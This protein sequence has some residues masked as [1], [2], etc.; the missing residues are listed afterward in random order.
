MHPASDVSSQL[1]R[2]MRLVGS[3]KA[4]AAARSPNGLEWSTYTVLFHLINEGPQRSKA[5]AD[6]MHSDP[7]TI[8][9]QATAL[10]ELGLVDRQRDPADGRA[11]LLAASTAGHELFATMRAHRDEMFRAVLADWSSE[12]AAVFT[13]LL[14]RFNTDFEQHIAEVLHMI[15]PDHQDDVRANARVDVRRD[16]SARTPSLQETT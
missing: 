1:V 8:S 5:L 13:A 9:R 10:V 7:S 3:V 16:N 14:G 2:L 11:A 4:Q 6:R 15:R 12:D